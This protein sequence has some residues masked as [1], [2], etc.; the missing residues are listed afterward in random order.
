MAA[1]ERKG[2][3]A[4]KTAVTTLV[5]NAIFATV[6]KS[7]EWH[8]RKQRERSRVVEDWSEIKPLV[9]RAQEYGVVIGIAAADKFIAALREPN[10]SQ[11]VMWG[12]PLKRF[13]LAQAREHKTAPF[14]F[15]VNK[16]RLAKKLLQ[17]YARSIRNNK[18]ALRMLESNSE[19]LIRHLEKILDL[20]IEKGFRSK[21]PDKRVVF[22]C[23]SECLAWI[24][25]PISYY[26]ATDW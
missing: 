15:E 11:F 7:K 20:N 14:L 8:Q 3:S 25:N 10:A 17:G 18:D 24:R 1:G 16:E 21:V 22:R 23:F 6:H 19:F 9:T 2:V 5:D 26:E 13:E 12:S 4:I